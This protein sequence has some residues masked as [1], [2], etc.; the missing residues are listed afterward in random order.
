MSARPR[1]CPACGLTESGTHTLERCR[2][3]LKGEPLGGKPGAP[4]TKWSQDALPEPP[5]P[6]YR[7][8]P[9]PPPREDETEEA[10]K[11]AEEFELTA[12]L[13]WSEA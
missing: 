2:R 6:D 7:M 5:P 13:R 8:G 10:T 12:A 4:I 1:P 11:P 3:A 9:K